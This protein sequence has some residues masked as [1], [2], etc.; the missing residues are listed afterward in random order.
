MLNERDFKKRFGSTLK[1][2]RKKQGMTQ[3]ELAY[4][5]NYSDKAISKW[6]RGES[7]P[8]SYTLYKIADL[9]CVS[10]DDIFSDNEEIKFIE[11]PKND[12]YKQLRIFIPLITVIGIMFVASLFFLVM[13]NV[14]EWSD[15]AYYPFLYALP[16]ASIALTV[17]SSLWWGVVES[18]IS[19]SMIIW[20]IA[21]SI[22]FSLKL[23]SIK[24]IFIPCIVL[25]AVC[26]IAYVFA[27][28]IIKK[29]KKHK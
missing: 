17:F 9:F 28:T 22:Y 4:K 16:V 8:D 21:F 1:H 18:C 15:K 10:M 7:V 2:L 27:H 26:I 5:L 3:G 29:E 23:E 13:K 11:K 19:V 6:E 12:S 24:Y 20:S 14:P 25:Q